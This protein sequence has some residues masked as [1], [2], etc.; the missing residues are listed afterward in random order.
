MFKELAGLASLLKNA[1]EIG[2]RLQAIGEELRSRRA[3][4]AAGGG[5]VEIEVNGLLEVLRC[6][7]DPK[8]VAQADR[9][10]LEDL[11]LAA[12]NQAV[13]KA[14]QYYSEVVRSAAAG[15][16]FPGLEEALGKMLPLKPTDSS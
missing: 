1:R 12:M 10:L 15:L 13:A 9:E 11:I 7:I 14:K 8:L 6:Q 2:G 5:L 16:N 4:G 3:T